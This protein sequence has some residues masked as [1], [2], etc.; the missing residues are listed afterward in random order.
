MLS[1]V[2]QLLLY[3]GV[4]SGCCGLPVSLPTTCAPGTWGIEAVAGVYRHY[5]GWVLGWGCFGGLI[6]YA[7]GA[8]TA[9]VV[10]AVAAVAAVVVAAFAPAAVPAVALPALL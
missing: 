8:S 10:V 2:P 7:W 5:C 3:E 9:D 6:V 1:G 4:L